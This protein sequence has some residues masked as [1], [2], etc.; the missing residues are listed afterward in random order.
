MKMTKKIP[1]FTITEILIVIVITSVVI[2]LAL[3]ILKMLQRHT[4]DIQKHYRANNEINLLNQKLTIDFANYTDIKWDLENE[5]LVFSTP[6]KKR[7]LSIKDTLIEGYQLNIK[8][9]YFYFLGKETPEGAIDAL[10]LILDFKGK[11]RTIFVYKRNDL[12]DLFKYGN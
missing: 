11:N 10:K 12:K 4:S 8:E 1:A 9:K 3:S 2:G 5:Q 6:I 7:S